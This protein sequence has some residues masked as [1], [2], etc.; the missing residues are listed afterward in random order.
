[1]VS[2][3]Q[4]HNEIKIRWNGP[5][6]D[7]KEKEKREICSVDDGLSAGNK[8]LLMTPP[9]YFRHANLTCTF[10]RTLG[11]SKSAT[12]H[13]HKG[14]REHTIIIRIGDRSTVQVVKVLKL[15]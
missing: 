15:V 8:T 10:S 1:M 11:L 13:M 3:P 14:P 6:L 9:H 12:Q 5:W 2:K 4:N 7:F